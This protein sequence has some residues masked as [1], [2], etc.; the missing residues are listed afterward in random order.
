MSTGLRIAFLSIILG[1]A[2]PLTAIAA[3]VAD[4]PGMALSWLGIVL[5][6]FIAF[7]RPGGR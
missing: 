1:T 2:I 6:A 4:L 5:V 3:S 7:G